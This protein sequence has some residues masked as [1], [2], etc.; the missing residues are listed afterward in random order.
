MPAFPFPTAC[1]RPMIRWHGHPSLSSLRLQ[2][3]DAVTIA[4][5]NP[6]FAGAEQ[7]DLKNFITMSY[8]KVLFCAG[9]PVFY[10]N[11]E[12]TFRTCDFLI[13]VV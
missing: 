5:N 1:S 4:I 10:H 11:V 9:N 7:K 2:E 8:F 6:V 3:A 12:R 13:R